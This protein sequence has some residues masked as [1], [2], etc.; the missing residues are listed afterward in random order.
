MYHFIFYSYF[1]TV[2]DVQTVIQHAKLCD[3]ELQ[4]V[5]QVLYFAPRIEVQGKYRFLE[6]DPTVLTNLHQGQRY[7]FRMAVFF[8]PTTSDIFC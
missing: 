1:R 4:P 7:L 5:T 6:L 8:I 3:G 2:E